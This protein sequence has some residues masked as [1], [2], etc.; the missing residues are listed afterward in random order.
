MS[1]CVSNVVAMLGRSHV[2]LGA[3]GFLGVVA[4][5]SLSLGHPMSPGELAAGT[6]VAA[7]ASL[8][9]DL[10]HPQATI[11]RSLGPVSWVASRL[12]SAISGGHRNGTHSLLA[13]GL[14][15]AGA[16]LLVLSGSLI[17]AYAVI[18]LCCALV[19]R[20]FGGMSELMGIACALAG[21]AG[22][23][24]LSSSLGWLTVA[25]AGGYALHIIGDMLTREGVPLAW[26]LMRTRTRLGLMR[27][28]GTLEGLVSIA[29]GL[30]VAVFA[31]VSIL[32][33]AIALAH[34]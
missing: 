22:V 2:A 32:S 16:H 12:I 1:G 33:P 5:V 14:V 17:G 25:V 27:T 31:W 26:P 24:A 10:D 8:L 9:P 28:G 34:P 23:L 13:L 20:L 3:A 7:G 11:S 15:G 18:A 4:P 19:L 29:C 30:M 21:A 6:V